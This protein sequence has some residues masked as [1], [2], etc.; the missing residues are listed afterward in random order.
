MVGDSLI[1]RLLAREA[2]L[3][4]DLREWP[5][6]QAEGSSMGFGRLRATEGDTE[7]AGKQ[8]RSE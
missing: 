5:R 4:V 3:P 7:D 6:L 2:G 1:S 8:C